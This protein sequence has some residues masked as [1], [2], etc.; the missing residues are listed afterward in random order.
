[1]LT[2]R[3]R[4]AR[5]RTQPLRHRPGLSLDRALACLRPGV[6]YLFGGTA[7]PGP[8]SA[9]TGSPV[10]AKHAYFGFVHGV[11]L[12]DIEESDTIAKAE[13]DSAL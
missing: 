2:D 9:G 1:M 6:Q 8:T 4:R 5:W 12:T 10:A 11:L 7:G 3:L 13:R